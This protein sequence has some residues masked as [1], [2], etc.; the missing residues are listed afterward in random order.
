MRY[1]RLQR[2]M[3]KRRGQKDE[4]GEGGEAKRESR[5]EL[6]DALQRVDDEGRETSSEPV[7]NSVKRTRRS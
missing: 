6:N 3:L 7:D 1:L 2:T 5:T 4:R